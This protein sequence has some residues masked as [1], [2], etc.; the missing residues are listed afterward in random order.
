MSWRF[1]FIGV[2]IACLLTGLWIAK[3]SRG[4]LPTLAFGGQHMQ[5]M[6]ADHYNWQQRDPRWRD[7]RLGNSNGT[8]GEYGC[9]VSAIANAVSNLGLELTPAALHQRLMEQ[10]GF[11]ERGWLIWGALD[12]ATEGRMQARV[13][14]RPSRDDVDGCLLEGHYP[15]VKFLIGGV[16][17][18]WVT[19]V[20][21]AQGRYLIRDP[22][23]DDA[24]PISLTSRTPLILSVRCIG[25]KSP[26]QQSAG[27]A[28]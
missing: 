7:V 12:R 2:L 3:H 24:D 13:F 21:K 18:H 20:G 9:T 1:V 28:E 17:Q 10:G 27:S 23:I 15:I 11:N 14:S 19:V 6:L 22:L 5:I 25:K 8:L 4:H 16:V 26:P